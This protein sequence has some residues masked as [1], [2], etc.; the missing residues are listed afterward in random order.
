[1]SSL[2]PAW[3]WLVVL[4]QRIGFGE[5]HDLHVKGGQPQFQPP[6]TVIRLVKF[7]MSRQHKWDATSSANFVMKREVLELI[8]ELRR[9]HDGRILRVGVRHGLPTDLVLE[10][11]CGSENHVG[12][13]R[14]SGRL[15]E[16]GPAAKGRIP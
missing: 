14:T 5:I 11:H 4:M 7:G 16:S 12:T 2:S 1:M 8:Q 3:R 9:L 6:P 10:E 15:T 13:K